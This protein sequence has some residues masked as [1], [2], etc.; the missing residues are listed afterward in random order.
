MGMVEEYLIRCRQQ[1]R[2]L[3]FK[4]FSSFAWSELV[5]CLRRKCAPSNCRQS[6]CGQLWHG[7]DKVMP[8]VPMLGRNLRC[9]L[10][11][12]F[13]GHS[14][15]GTWV[16][17]RGVILSLW[18]QSRVLGQRFLKCGPR[19]EASALLGTLLAMQLLGLTQTHWTKTLGVGLSSLS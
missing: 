5:G 19:P 16:E 9:C 1:H 4:L 15:T 11:R 17:E 13:W 6:Y 7:S 18:K 2:W 12:W 3:G 8:H 10:S 14:L